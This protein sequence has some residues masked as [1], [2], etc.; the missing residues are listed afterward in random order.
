MS[1]VQLLDQ[2]SN[3]LISTRGTSRSTGVMIKL[4]DN[5]IISISGRDL[6]EIIDGL[7]AERI[8]ILVWMH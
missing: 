4:D 7:S 2:F 6:P 5:G 1:T 3:V 8:S